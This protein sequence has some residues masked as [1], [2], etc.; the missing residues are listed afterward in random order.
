[1]NARSRN[2]CASAKTAHRDNWG[3][4]SR[5]WLGATAGNLIDRLT[6]R[7]VRWTGS[8]IELQECPWLLGPSGAA[9]RIGVEWLAAEIQRNSGC[10]YDGMHAGLLP[11]LDVLQGSGFNTARLH[12]DVVDFY[13]RTADWE[14]LARVK[15]N[16][17]ARPFGWVLVKLFSQRLDQLCLPVRRADLVGS[18]HSHVV[19]VRD[20]T[21]THIGS[22]WL[23]AS[24]VGSTIFSGWYSA[25]WLPG[26]DRAR[27]R[28]VFPLPNGSLTILLRPELGPQG[29]LLLSSPAGGCA[30]EGAYLIVRAVGTE[31]W[32][33]RV[34]I[35]EEFIVYVDSD[36]V[37]RTDH[38]IRLWRINLA[39]FR[40]TIVRRR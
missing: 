6:Q 20:R 14:L 29:S 16:P 4:R 39:S 18:M 23:R 25:E 9:H 12:P 37:L 38:H 33:R 26:A 1:M 30:Q 10:T 35:D 19:T 28:V 13:E 36:G 27:I 8:R 31:A 5:L 11:S 40:Y 17:F 3:Q 15:W 2:S 34:P 32:I 7:W 22:A 21:G 24:A